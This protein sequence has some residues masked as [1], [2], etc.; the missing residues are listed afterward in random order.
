MREGEG[1]MWMNEMLSYIEHLCST[2]VT[3]DVAR[4]ITL[5]ERDLSYGLSRSVGVST[6]R[7]E[8]CKMKKE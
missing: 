2:E 6:A 1:G 7:G 8:G 5:S 3:L 4:E